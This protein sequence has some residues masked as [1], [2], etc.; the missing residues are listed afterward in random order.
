MTVQ[1]YSVRN[2]SEVAMH[3]VETHGVQMVHQPQFGS[4]TFAS[5]ATRTYR[6]P[7][8]AGLRFPSRCHDQMKHCRRGRQV[9]QVDGSPSAAGHFAFRTA[10]W[11]DDR[12]PEHSP[13]VLIPL[14]PCPSPARLQTLN[15]FDVE[16]LFAMARVA[17][18]QPLASARLPEVR[19]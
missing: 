7:P 11:F 8:L 15:L 17:C 5:G 10:P 19:I 13:C 16:K 14:D 1:R 4:A 2:L 6:S 18:G 12:R 3:A 9:T